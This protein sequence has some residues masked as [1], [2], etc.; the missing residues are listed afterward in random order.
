[1]HGSTYV[2]FLPQIRSFLRTDVLSCK[3]QML[4]ITPEAVSLLRPST[5][6]YISRAARSVDI[7]LKGR[8]EFIVDKP[9]SPHVNTTTYIVS[10]LN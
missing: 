3:E 1:M 6:L 10:K 2:S 7:G 5:I 9:G 4:A 8:T